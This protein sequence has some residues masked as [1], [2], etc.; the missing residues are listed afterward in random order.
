MLHILVVAQELN[1]RVPLLVNPQTV[2]RQ[3]PLSM[4]LSRQEYWSRL[5]FPP[6]GYLTDPVMGPMSLVYP[7][8][9]G[10]YFT[11]ELPRKPLHLLVL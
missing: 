2:A 5:S 10:R 11:I 8:L 7:A 3:A 4:G 6:P 9:A 1:S